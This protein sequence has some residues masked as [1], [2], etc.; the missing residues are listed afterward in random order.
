MKGRGTDIGGLLSS[1]GKRAGISIER[2]NR[3]LTRIP[4]FWV[5]TLATLL[6]LGLI[7]F[8]GLT[9]LAARD[10]TLSNEMDNLARLSLML[11]EH[12]QRV[13]FG[14]D[15]LASS[16]EEQISLAGVRS[17]EEFRQHASTKE[18]HAM[19]QER[20]VLM[21]EVDSLALIDKNGMLINTSRSWPPPLADL[22]DRDYFTILRDALPAAHVISAPRKDRLTGQETIFLAHRIS[23]PDGAF[24]GLVLVT[25]ST[26][27]FEKLFTAV[28]PNDGASIS[29]YRRDGILLIRQPPSGDAG[30]QSPEIQQF[31]QETISR[32]EQGTLRTATFSAESTPRLM[33]LHTVRGYPLMINVANSESTVLAEWWKLAQLIF[34]F[35]TAAIVLVVLL[36]LAFVRQSRMQAQ[37][38]ETAEQLARAN[39][40]LTAANEELESFSYSVAHDLR[41]QLRTIDGYSTI[42]L[43]ETRDK[44]GEESAKRLDRI[45]AGAMRMNSLIDDLLQLSRIARSGLKRRDFDLS[46]LALSVAGSLSEAHSGRGI[47]VVVKP[48]MR[49]SGDP[50]L[51][52]SVLEN[53]LGNAW[54]FTSRTDGARVEV[55]AEE[56]DGEAIYFVR[57]NGAGF[58]M[59]YSDRLFKPFQRLHRA[60]EFEGTGIGL[61]IVQRIV[62]RH[63]GRVWAESEAGKE[64][65]FRFTLG[66]APRSGPS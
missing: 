58:N 17:S 66:K 5:E 7:A 42:L 48:G 6:V 65:V 44:L 22:S 62:T 49:A 39:E 2:A 20:V 41:A 12:T 47:E 34:A 9:A 8:A 25:I 59:R 18:T 16:I 43:K 3:R 51:V 36:G 50:H 45:R 15:I 55:G 35:A 60:D 38:V 1:V 57:D 27:R 14:A 46:E 33:A 53:L 23:T 26:S 29:L 28:L 37:V 21:A 31:L 11:A 40:K 54:K 4:V 32:A 52:R 56:R 10:K 13:I 30:D 19:L 64:T 63:G 24:L 61:S